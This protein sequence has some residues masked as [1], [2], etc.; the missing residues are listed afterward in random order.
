MIFISDL[1][2]PGGQLSPVHGSKLDSTGCFGWSIIHCNYFVGTTRWKGAGSRKVKAQ[3]VKI[4]NSRGVSLPKAVIEQV[5]L[6]DEVEL[7]V[8]KD[9]IVI[10]PAGGDP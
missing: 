9:R 5:G 4:G 7:E 10:R 2:V 1:G 3:L 8:Q 6:R